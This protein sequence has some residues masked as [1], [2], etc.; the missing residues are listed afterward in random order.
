MEER[1]RIVARMDL[2]IVMEIVI[3]VQRQKQIQTVPPTLLIVIAMERATKSP[4]HKIVAHAEMYVLRTVQ[5][6]VQP[7]KEILFVQLSKNATLFFSMVLY[8][9]VHSRKRNKETHL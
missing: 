7:W 9:Q 1:R 3:N 6:V 2:S 4:L 5:C 8:S